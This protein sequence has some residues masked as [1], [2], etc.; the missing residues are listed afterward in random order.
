MKKITSIAVALILMSGAVSAQKRFVHKQAN[1]AK[2]ERKAGKVQVNKAPAQVRKTVAPLYMPLHEDVYFYE[3]EW[4]KTGETDYTY[5]TRGNVLTSNYVT[6]EGTMLTEYVY[7]EDNLWT[8]KTESSYDEGMELMSSSRLTRAFDSEVKD[9]VVENLEYTLADGEWNMA[10]YGRTWKRIVTRDEQGRVTA[11]SVETYYMGNFEPTRRN[12]ITYNAD[13]LAETWKHEELTYSGF[14]LVWE[15][16]YTLSDMQWESTDGQIVAEDIDAFFTGNNRLKSA[17]VTEPDYGVVGTITATYEENGSYSYAFN[18]IDPVASDVFKVTYTDENGSWE[19]E[20]LYY[21]D[22][23]ED[24]ELSEEELME[25]SK[26]VVTCNEMGDITSEEY[27][28][29]DMFDSG[30][31][32]DMV[33]GDYSYPMEWTMSEYDYDLEDYLPFLKLVRSNYVD[34]TNTTAINGVQT[35]PATDVEGVYNMQGVRIGQSSDRLPA[36]IYIVKK[37]GKTQKIVRK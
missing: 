19:E 35:R 24:G 4:M 20:L 15:E 22:M 21:E 36:G 3:D 10:D 13:G 16:F 27:Y 9:L 7:N 33:Y 30:A 34:V 29:Y 37:D 2:M 11:V 5:D 26:V 6:E 14:D 12:T 8:S 25:S 32:Y 31:K 28:F 1:A 23:D 18:Y 17:K